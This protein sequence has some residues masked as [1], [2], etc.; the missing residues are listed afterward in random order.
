VTLSVSGCE[1][2][3]CLRTVSLKDS[4]GN[5]IT[6]SGATIVYQ[7]NSSGSYIPFGDGALDASGQKAALVDGC[8][9]NRY[10]LT[11]LGATQEKQTNSVDVTYQTQKVTVELRDSNG[12]LI[13]GNDG[14]VV[15]QPGSAGS[16]VQFGSNAD[17]QANGYTSMETLPLTNRYHM[18]YLTKTKEKQSGGATVTYYVAEFQ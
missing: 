12:A 13:T 15:W 17:L 4:A 3:K 11:Y 16:Y 10:R 6:S 18:T 7:P 8:G 14:T 5:L 9:T 1:I 2:S